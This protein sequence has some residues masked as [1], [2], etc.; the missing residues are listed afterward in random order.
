MMMMMAMMIIYYLLV[1]ITQSWLAFALIVC[2]TSL[3]P[4]LYFGEGLPVVLGKHPLMHFAF[5]A[6]P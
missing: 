2:I 5:H 1:I 6:F 3:L 4:F